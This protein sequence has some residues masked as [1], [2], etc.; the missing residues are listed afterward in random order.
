MDVGPQHEKSVRRNTSTIDL[1]V[2][3]SKQHGLFEKFVGGMLI[4]NESIAT[5]EYGIQ[6]RACYC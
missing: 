3:R 6:E 2:I 5:T 4:E 1:L